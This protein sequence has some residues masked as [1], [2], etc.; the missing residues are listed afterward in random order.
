MIVLNPNERERIRSLLRTVIILLIVIVAGQLVFK[1]AVVPNIVLKKIKVES[2]IELSDSEIRSIAGIETG[3][4]YYNLDA[5]DIKSRLEKYPPIRKAS[6]EKI[7]PDKLQ[8]YLFGRKA[9]A[10]SI[11]N[12]N[13][14]SVPVAIDGEGVVFEKGEDM[15]DWDLPVISGIN[16]TSV[17]L[18]DGFPVPLLPLLEDLENMRD[19]DR[20]L[21]DLISEIRVEKRGEQG[22]DLILFLHN[23][24]LK[25]RTGRKLDGDVLKNIIMVFDVLKQQ[26]L[27]EKIGEV[28]FRSKEIIYRLR[29]E[30]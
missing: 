4:Y 30:V 5:G 18:G 24:P 6:V 14:K 28:D 17:Q 3:H 8:L 29:E 21:Y 20:A 27:T 10:Q 16:F 19:R 26:K 12:I 7:F 23:Y 22:Y 25:A 11:L 15:D 2:D 9:V 1:I 13:E